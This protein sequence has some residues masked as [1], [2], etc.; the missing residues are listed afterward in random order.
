MCR[1]T[2]YYKGKCL[3]LN[4]GLCAVF[5]LLFVWFNHSCIVIFKGNKTLL[6]VVRFVIATMLCTFTYYKKLELQKRNARPS[7]LSL[8]LV[9]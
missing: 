3:K 7:T 2:K 8:I 6:L 4:Y 1:N 5:I 9:N